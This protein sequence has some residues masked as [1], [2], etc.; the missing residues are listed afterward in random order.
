MEA[1][2]GGC[3]AQD[4]DKNTDEA[5]KTTIMLPLEEPRSTAKLYNIM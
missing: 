5:Q 3:P 2:V 1:N 4:Q